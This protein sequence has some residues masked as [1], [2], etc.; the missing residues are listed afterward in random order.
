M[1]LDILLNELKLDMQVED[2]GPPPDI[3]ECAVCGNKWNVSDCETDI[4]GNYESGYYTI[5]LCPTCE[6]GGCI[7]D[8][9]YSEKQA[10]KWNEWHD[11][12]K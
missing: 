3:A 10:E 11:R 4:E 1:K 7:D 2:H 12:H 9:S 6:D 5:H 8:Y